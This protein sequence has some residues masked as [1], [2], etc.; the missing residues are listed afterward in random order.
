M[1]HVLLTIT[2]LRAHGL[3]TAAVI[4]ASGEIEADV[5]VPGA[6]SSHERI[7]GA[8]RLSAGKLS[9]WEIQDLEIAT[10]TPPPPI[11][12]YN[13]WHHLRDPQQLSSDD[14]KEMY[15]KFSLE[16]RR[17]QLISLAI[18]FALMILMAM[19]YLN[20][21]APP[22]L[23]GQKAARAP[24]F[25][26][27]KFGLFY[28]PDTWEDFDAC[29]CACCCPAIRGA[30][31]LSVV[32]GFLGFWTAF[33]AWN[34]FV[35]LDY[36]L[37]L[38]GH[39]PEREMV[40]NGYHLSLLTWG[41]FVALLVYWRSRL[42]EVFGMHR[43]LASTSGDCLLYCCCTCCAVAQEARHVEEAIRCGSANVQNVRSML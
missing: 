37:V 28:L 14:I 10:E 31:T 35:F 32:R 25:A 42:R 24:D 33:L 4:G 12:E 29:L 18:W 20:T 1:R 34:L 16:Y 38:F 6:S 41:G 21:R 17:A 3:E 23:D 30:E 15:K 7:R 39:G 26:D 40:I 5:D 8:T 2:V 11:K 43:G 13:I 27:W 19:F 22:I 36:G 9:V